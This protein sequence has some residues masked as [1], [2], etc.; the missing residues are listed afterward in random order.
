MPF[1]ETY[2]LRL[3]IRAWKIFLRACVLCNSLLRVQMARNIRAVNV[4]IQHS[5]THRASD[6]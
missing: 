6:F 5:H 1:D 3:I 2:K 4:N